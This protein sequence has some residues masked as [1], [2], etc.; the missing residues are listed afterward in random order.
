MIRSDLLFI[1]GKVYHLG[2]EPGQLSPNIFLVGDPARAHKLAAHFDQIDFQVQNRE[3]LT[4]TGAYRGVPMSV[5][6]TGIGT[7]NVEIVLVEAYQ[8]LYFDPENSQLK[9]HTPS[10]NMIRI[11]T[12]GGIQPDIQVGTM[13]ISQYALGL[14]STG[15][16]YDHP[17][18]DETIME[19][20]TACEEV[21]N[22]YTPS[23][24]RFRNK[25]S[26]Y[27][28]KATPR[29]VQNLLNSAKEMNIIAKPG[30]TVSSPGFYGPCGRVIEGLINTIPDIKF[31]LTELVIKDLKVVNMEMESSLIFH[32]GHQLNFSCGT[33]CPVI[34]TP[35]ASSALINYDQIIDDAIQIGLSAMVKSVKPD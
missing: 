1:D 29:I 22:K 3:F 31:K 27:A 5:I 21:L 18:A 33:I 11:G 32:L 2:L 10:I 4:L 14:D 25:F 20:E 34:S 15:L 26:P 30:I 7:D 23:H 35:Q 13:A 19:I 12:S 16:F 9:G 28:S 8:L 17:P 6:G 24:A